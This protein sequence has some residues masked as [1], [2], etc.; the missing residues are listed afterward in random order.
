MT[1]WREPRSEGAPWTWSILWPAAW[2]WQTVMLWATGVK[3]DLRL[4]WVTP[5]DAVF[6]LT[7]AGREALREALEARDQS[8]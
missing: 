8:P 7:P 2:L 5:D 3:E 6:T 4:W 1:W